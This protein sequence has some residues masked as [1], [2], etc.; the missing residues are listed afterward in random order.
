MTITRLKATL[1]LRI[2]IA[3]LKRAYAEARERR[4]GGAHQR[5]YERMGP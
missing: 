1:E 3:T 2:D 5:P 4:G